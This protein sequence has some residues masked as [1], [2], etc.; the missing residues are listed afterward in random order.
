MQFTL[1]WLEAIASYSSK[2]AKQKILAKLELSSAKFKLQCK[3]TQSD[4]CVK[5]T[6]NKKSEHENLKL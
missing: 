3:N 1:S 2:T 4:L 6:E 5:K